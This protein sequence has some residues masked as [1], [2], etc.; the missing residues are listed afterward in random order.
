M[1]KVYLIARQRILD[2]NTLRLLDDQGLYALDGIMYGKKRC[3]PSENLD[4]NL[5]KGMVREFESENP[6]FCQRGVDYQLMVEGAD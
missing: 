5:M 3:V 2:C 6:E 4:D 1:G